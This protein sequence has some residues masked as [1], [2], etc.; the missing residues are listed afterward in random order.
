MEFKSAHVL[1][2]RCSSGSAQCRG[3]AGNL[4]TAVERPPLGLAQISLRLI[5]GFENQDL[6]K[7]MG[8]CLRFLTD[9]TSVYETDLSGQAQ[10]PAE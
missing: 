5:P 9:N 3:S 8:K 10:K 7:E 1:S 2:P 6:G 4:A